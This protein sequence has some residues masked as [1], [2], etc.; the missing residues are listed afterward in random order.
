M[1]F[2]PILAPRMMRRTTAAA[3][4]IASAAQ[5]LAT[6]LHWPGID[7]PFV[8]TFGIPCPG[9]GL[10]RACAAMLTGD[11]HR[12]LHMHAFAVPVLVGVATLLIAAALP[13]AAREKIGRTVERVELRTGFVFL[14]L[15]ALLIYWLGR[16]LYA[17]HEFISLIAQH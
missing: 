2:R 1:P 17:P 8:R 16:L 9:C 14:L 11:P 13:A 15:T 12:S 10:S 4:G 3:I 7:C 6:A 5:I